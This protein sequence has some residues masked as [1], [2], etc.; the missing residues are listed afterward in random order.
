[1]T[2]GRSH[3]ARAEGLGRTARAVAALRR[4]R[5]LWSSCFH[6]RWSNFADICWPFR[7]DAVSA[8]YCSVQVTLG[9]VA[10]PLSK[11]EGDSGCRGYAIPCFRLCSVIICDQMTPARRPPRAAAAMVEA[12]HTLEQHCVLGTA[13]IKISACLDCDAVSPLGS[14]VMPG[15]A[16]FKPHTTA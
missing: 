4:R 6:L 10:R 1:M 8:A 16:S 12:T 9:V 11:R 5:A 14:E 15:S 13:V 3:C 2:P 7:L